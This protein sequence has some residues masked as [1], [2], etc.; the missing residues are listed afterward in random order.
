MNKKKLVAVSG[1]CNRAQW[2]AED[3]FFIVQPLCFYNFTCIC[4]SQK[5]FFRHEFS[6]D[7][8]L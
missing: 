3:T 4:Y 5:K 1:E 7:V 6:Q 2:C 8:S